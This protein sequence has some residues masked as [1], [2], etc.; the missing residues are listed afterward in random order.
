MY[1]GGAPLTS[2]PDLQSRAHLGEGACTTFGLILYLLVAVWGSAVCT[3]SAARV[4][5]RRGAC[6]VILPKIFPLGPLPR[7]RVD[8]GVYLVALGLFIL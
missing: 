5:P 7:D 3:T 8:R 1:W 2:L 4:G 6:R